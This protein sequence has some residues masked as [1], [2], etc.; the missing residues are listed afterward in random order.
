V[1]RYKRGKQ[2]SNEKENRTDKRG[3]CHLQAEALFLFGKP[4]KLWYNIM[5]LYGCDMVAE[6]ETAFTRLREGA[7]KGLPFFVSIKDYT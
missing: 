6:K 2:E 1:F 4:V 3:H 7:A 5:Y